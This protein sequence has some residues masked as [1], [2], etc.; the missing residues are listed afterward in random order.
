[1]GFTNDIFYYHGTYDIIGIV[2]I[3]VMIVIILII[4][5]IDDI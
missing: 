4:G 5:E 3:T 2:V 1:L